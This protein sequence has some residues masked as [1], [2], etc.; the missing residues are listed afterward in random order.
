MDKLRKKLPLDCLLLP[1]EHTHLDAV[2]VLRRGQVV[3][4]R[5]GHLRRHLQRL[6]HTGLHLL[7]I[8]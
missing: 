8:Q 7:E 6:H 3:Q 4:R 1:V 2:P 5:A